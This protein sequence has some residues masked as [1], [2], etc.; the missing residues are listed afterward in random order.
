M[1]AAAVLPGERIQEYDDKVPYTA[2]VGQFNGRVVGQLKVYDL[3]GN[4]HEW[5]SDDYGVLGEYSVARGASWK[6]HS[7]KHLKAS[8]R[9]PVRKPDGAAEVDSSGIYGFRVVLA[10]V[11]VI[12]EKEAEDAP[13]K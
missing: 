1:V 10:K 6:T 8:A 13:K 11:P 12:T 5:V 2:P 9:K 7:E 3:E 4:V